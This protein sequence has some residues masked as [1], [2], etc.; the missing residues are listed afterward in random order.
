MVIFISGSINSGKTTTAKALAKKLDAQCIDGDD[1]KE[2]IPNFDLSKDI[3]KVI[4]LIVAK[5][6]NLTYA[7]QSVV[8]SYPI[9]R[10]NYKQILE[11]L[12]DKNPQFIT[13]T[14]RLEIAQSKRGN[15]ELTEWEVARIRHHYETGIAS[16]S[17]GEAIDNSELSVDETVTAIEGLIKQ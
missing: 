15:R 7:G 16:P 4:A 14:P 12:H 8:V 13:L 17:F 6:N 1:V 11:G 9:S 5:I 3:P 2:Q 10:E